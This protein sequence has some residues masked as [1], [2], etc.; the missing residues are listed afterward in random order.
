[1]IKDLTILC[2]KYYQ[3][4]FPIQHHKWDNL[5]KKEFEKKI[6]LLYQIRK[7]DIVR[8]ENDARK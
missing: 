6:P 4:L 8:F 7:N 2:T 5:T 1:M 3:C